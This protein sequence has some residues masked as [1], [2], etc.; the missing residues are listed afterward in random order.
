MTPENYFLQLHACHNRCQ[1]KTP[2]YFF[3]AQEAII[4]QLW[5]NPYSVRCCVRLAKRQGFCTELSRQINQLDSHIFFFPTISLFYTRK[6]QLPETNL[7]DQ[8]GFR[9]PHCDGANSGKATMRLAIVSLLALVT[10]VAATV[11]PTPMN[12]K[13][14]RVHEPYR[15]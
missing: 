5:S 3:R 11:V 1:L 7:L 8:V 15:A 14:L 13:A 10:A 2:N 6:N 12:W 9:L 4:S